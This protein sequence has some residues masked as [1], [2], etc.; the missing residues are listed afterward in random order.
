MSRE[1]VSL[2]ALAVELQPTNVGF[3]NSIVRLEA[4]LITLE[5]VFFQLVPSN[6][7]SS[8][9]FVAATIVFL[10]SAVPFLENEIGNAR[11]VMSIPKLKGLFVASDLA[12]SKLVPSN[13]ELITLLNQ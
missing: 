1:V 10:K 12:S 9:S 2:K 11:S 4:A 13:V 6:L 5:I 3:K 8:A 7:G